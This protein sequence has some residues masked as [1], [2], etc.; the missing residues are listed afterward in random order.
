[1]A[2]GRLL[3]GR[4]VPCRCLSGSA[5]SALVARA[6]PFADGWGSCEPSQAWG[7]ELAEG[8]VRVLPCEVATAPK[9]GTGARAPHTEAAFQGQFFPRRVLVGCGVQVSCRVRA[10]VPG[11]SNSQL[12]T[13][14]S[15]V[16]ICLLI[17]GE[18]QL[19]R[20]SR[21]PGR[22]RGGPPFHPVSRDAT[23]LQPIQVHK[24]LSPWRGLGRTGRHR[25]EGV[26]LGVL[27]PGPRPLR[28]G[29]G[30]WEGVGEHTW[31]VS[32]WAPARCCH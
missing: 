16:S 32:G 7:D 13:S 8:P 12:V 6:W 14:F 30:A 25:P 2:R 9:S 27:V 24:G 28:S 31:K 4:Q 18:D 10:G 3:Q 15:G 22:Q 29:T 26:C 17:R 21:W 23:G 19:T 1:M 20:A 5:L 11:P